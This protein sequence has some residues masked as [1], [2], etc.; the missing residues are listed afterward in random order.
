MSAELKSTPG[1]WFVDDVT[2]MPVV[3]VTTHAPPY[4]TDDD[5]YSALDEIAVLYGDEVR[6]ANARLI[7]AAP[8]LLAALQNLVPR[9]ERACAYAENDPETIALSVA[10]AR[11][12]IAKATGTDR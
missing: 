8:E 10:D 1:P 12:A 7:A 3:Y 2:N 6:I 9:F 11:A 4:S 5:G